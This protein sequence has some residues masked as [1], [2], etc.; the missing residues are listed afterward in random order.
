MEVITEQKSQMLVKRL[1][2]R[3]VQLQ[4]SMVDAPAIMRFDGLTLKIQE[5]R[6]ATSS[7]L[8][9]AQALE[10][11][12]AFYALQNPFVIVDIIRQLFQ[13]NVFTKEISRYVMSV[14]SPLY[15]PILGATRAGAAGAL[16]GF[17]EGIQDLAGFLSQ[18]SWG[19]SIYLLKRLQ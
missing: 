9:I 5:F 14:T 4:L 13:K 11:I 17:G 2:I 10:Q 18:E 16:S 3:A 19:L 6:L 7:P 12:H 1:T 15:K 8:A